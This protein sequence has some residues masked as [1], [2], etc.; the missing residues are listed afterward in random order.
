[1]PLGGFVI[2]VGRCAV[3]PFAKNA[4]YMVGV[5]RKEEPGG[6]NGGCLRKFIDKCYCF[7][8]GI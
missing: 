6:A 3:L 8:K 4:D 5:L 1:M 2:G 7:V